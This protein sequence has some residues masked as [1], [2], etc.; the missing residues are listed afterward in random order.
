MAQEKTQIEINREQQEV[1]RKR[2]SAERKTKKAAGEAALGGRTLSEALRGATSTRERKEIRR[3]YEKAELA[4][5]DP[6][7]QK[8][9]NNLKPIGNGSLEA[10]FNTRSVIIVENGFLED[11]DIV[12]F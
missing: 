1:E 4:A 11:I 12:V 9:S 8:S 10:Q 5:L 3:R 6:F 7:A 2:R